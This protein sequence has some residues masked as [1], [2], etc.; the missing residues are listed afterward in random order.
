V[1]ATLQKQLPLQQGGGA[2]DQLEA[3]MI[4]YKLN[5]SNW[6]HQNTH[7]MAVKEVLLK[8]L[9][10]PM[11]ANAQGMCKHCYKRGFSYRLCGVPHLML[12]IITVTMTTSIETPHVVLPQPIA[13][14]SHPATSSTQYR[15]PVILLIQFPANICKVELCKLPESIFAYTP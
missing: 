13:W 2:W 3:A 10:L 12:C 5:V 15:H 1:P 11:S 7:I 4:A 6:P 14:F 8:A 9:L